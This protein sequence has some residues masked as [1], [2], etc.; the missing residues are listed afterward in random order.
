VVSSTVAPSASAHRT[1]SAM[2]VAL[3]ALLLLAAAWLLAGPELLDRLLA[4]AG[5]PVH[6]AASRRPAPVPWRTPS[7]RRGRRHIQPPRS[8][9]SRSWTVERFRQEEGPS[10]TEREA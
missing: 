10:A 3:A 1:L 7:G 6:G 9:R 8:S 4:L 2:V 5:Q